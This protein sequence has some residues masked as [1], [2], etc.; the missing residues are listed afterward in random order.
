LAFHLVGSGRRQIPVGREPFPRGRLAQEFV[1]IL[2]LLGKAKAKPLRKHLIVAMA[3]GAIGFL[4]AKNRREGG[5]RVP[6]GLL[7]AQRRDQ[8]QAAENR[9]H[10]RQDVAP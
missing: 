8:Q 10:A 2:F 9:G 5:M 7:V 4:R 6:A 1:Q 3:Q